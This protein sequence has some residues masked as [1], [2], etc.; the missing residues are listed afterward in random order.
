MLLSDL[1]DH[2]EFLDSNILV[3]VIFMLGVS[4]LLK[5]WNGKLL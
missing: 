5:E 3:R 4:L 1:I 2:F